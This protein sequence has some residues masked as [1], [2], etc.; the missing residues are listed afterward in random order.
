V[1]QN[2]LYEIIDPYKPLRLNFIIAALSLEQSINLDIA[3][4]RFNE[5]EITSCRKEPFKLKSPKLDTN[6]ISPEEV[7]KLLIVST[8]IKFQ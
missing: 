5:D 3:K 8:Y 4:C 1:H 7:N 6:I 2:R